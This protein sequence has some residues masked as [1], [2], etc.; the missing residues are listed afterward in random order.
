MA[1]VI[2]V[3]ALIR[4]GRNRVFAHRRSP[5]RRLLPGTWDVVGGHAE[6]GETWPG[7]ATG[8]GG[9]ATSWPGR[10]V[11]ECAGLL[12]ARGADVTY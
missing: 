3:G 1:P 11:T 10:P 5:T 6:P 7:A 9:C 12:T 2:C 8:T 4:D